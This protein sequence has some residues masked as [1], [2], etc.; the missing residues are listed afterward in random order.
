MDLSD[1]GDAVGG[2]RETEPQ[3]GEMRVV[4]CRAR[5][6][7]TCAP[8]G[9]RERVVLTFKKPCWP[10]V[11]LDHSASTAEGPSPGHSRPPGARWPPGVQTQSGQK[12]GCQD[13]YKGGWPSSN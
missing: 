10:A 2:N 6:R 4:G 8:L 13:R 1:I 12:S 3:A 5:Q 11:D 9:G 7:W